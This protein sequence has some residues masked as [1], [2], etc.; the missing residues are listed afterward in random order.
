MIRKQVKQ[1]LY[2]YLFPYGGVMLV[3]LIAATYRVRILDSENETQ[4]LNR[5]KQLVYASWH[6]RFFPGITFFSTRK[7]IAIMISKSRDGEMAARAVDYLGWYPVRGSSSRGGKEALEEIKAL[8]ASQYKIG[9]IVGRAPG[10]VWHGQTRADPY[11]PV[12]G[13]ADCA[14]HYLRVKHRWMFNS[15]D[16][17]M[18]PKPFSR[19]IIRF[20][21][22]IHVPSEMD[23]TAFEAKRLEVQERL[24]ALYEETRPDMERQGKG[25]GCFFRDPGT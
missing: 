22:A 14:D 1:F 15:W 4:I 10:A 8:A 12:C 5:K 20:G 11:C 21:K 18:V 24:A 19:V 25:R 17:F 6:Q 16:R 2:R 7:P 13:P 9:H 23:S 3:R